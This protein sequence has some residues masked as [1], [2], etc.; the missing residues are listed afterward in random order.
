MVRVTGT[1]Q[2][3]VDDRLAK[4]KGLPQH[5]PATKC[6]ANLKSA[7][8]TM[9][10]KMVKDGIPA[11]VFKYYSFKSP[12]ILGSL[13][14]RTETIDVELAKFA[15]AWDAKGVMRWEFE[16]D[17][18]APEVDMKSV[19]EQIAGGISDGWGEGVEQM[20]RFGP[21]CVSDDYGTKG[22]TTRL[23]T[24]K[25]KKGLNAGEHGRYAVLLTTVG[26]KFAVK[27]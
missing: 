25:E 23:A 14:G 22:E 27:K 13:F 16:W 1:L 11:D 17:V 9:V 12:G 7:V 26:A 4:R 3:F 24:S 18:Q 2:V 5:M 20:F 21:I 8:S 15:T 19:R 10:R 6:D